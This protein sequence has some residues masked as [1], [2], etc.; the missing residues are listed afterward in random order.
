[1]LA[2]VVGLNRYDYVKPETGER[3]QGGSIT[4]LSKTSGN[5]RKGFNAIEL[6][7]PYDNLD[8]FEKVP[9]VYDLE[10]DSVPL[11]TGG[12]VRQVYQSCS[13]IA[14][15]DLDFAQKLKQQRDQQK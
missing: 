3:K 6:S 5:G 12:G 7:I 2:T 10:L 13:L 4:Y 15:V 14:P 8:N 9:G 11:R 1:M